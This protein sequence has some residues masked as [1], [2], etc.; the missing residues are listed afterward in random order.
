MSKISY[1]KCICFIFLV[2]LVILSCSGFPIDN[3]AMSDNSKKNFRT[4]SSTRSDDFLNRIFNLR[5]TQNIAPFPSH[6]LRHLRQLRAQT[7][8]IRTQPKMPMGHI[9]AIVIPNDDDSLPTTS[10]LYAQVPSTDSFYTLP[11]TKTINTRSQRSYSNSRQR[12]K[13]QDSHLEHFSVKAYKAEI[14]I[15]VKAQSIKKKKNC[16]TY[17]VHF[18]VLTLLKNS[19]YPIHPYIH[20]QFSN[21]TGNCDREEHGG[22]KNLVKADIRASREYILFLNAPKVNKFSV[23][24]APEWI[25]GKKQEDYVMKILKKV[26]SPNFKIK[27]TRISKLEDKSSWRGPKPRLKLVCR[28]VGLP[29][30]QIS[31]RRDNKTLSNSTSV[32][33]TY[34]KRKSTLVIRLPTDHDLGKHE[35]VAKGVDGSTAIKSIEVH[36]P[37]SKTTPPTPFSEIVSKKPCDTQY[38]EHFCL[39]EGKC[40][41][42]L[43]PFEVYCECPSGFAGKRCDEKTS[44]QPASM[45]PQTSLFTC[46]L[47]LSTKYYC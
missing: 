28:A 19:S 25:K 3:V 10:E 11:P 27:P 35:C 1:E 29:F 47:G 26:C 36:R 5:S 41:M 42:D 16:A 12:T 46:K 40:F 7:R 33:I 44:F 38:N 18:Q 24:G 8:D 4:S 15:H 32:R 31:W 23:V 30:P 22:R 43:Q 13:S 2:I 21:S 20:V 17:L 37:S 39:N 9:E 14:V 45:Y 34:V 6:K